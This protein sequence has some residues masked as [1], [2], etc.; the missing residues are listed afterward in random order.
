M[1]ERKIRTFKIIY[2]S[3]VILYKH[4]PIVIWST[5]IH[6]IAL[7]FLLRQQLIDDQTIPP[8][9]RSILIISKVTTEMD[10]T[11]RIEVNN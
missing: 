11:N 1:V 7:D 9:S 3:Y 5:D 8:L 4:I 6:L 2:C 10:A